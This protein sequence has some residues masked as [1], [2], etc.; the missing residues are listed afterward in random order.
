MTERQDVV[1]VEA[2][3]AF[4]HLCAMVV[5]VLHH[6]RW[7]VFVDWKLCGLLENNLRQVGGC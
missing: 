5:V 6:L 3:A 7:W 2:D 4:G 1:S